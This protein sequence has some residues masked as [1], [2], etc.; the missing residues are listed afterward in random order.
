M[1]ASRLT[2]AAFA[3]T[4]WGGARRFLPILGTP[5]LS[6]LHT[7]AATSPS[8]ES[9]AER[10]ASL[11]AEAGLA[12]LKTVV[13]EE[14]ATILRLPAG[15]IDPAR[16]LSEMGMDSLMAVELRL[17]LESRLRVDLPLVSLAEGTSVASIAARL[18]GAIS[19]GPN[20]GELTAL[21]AR[22]EGAGDTPSP[23]GAGRAASAMLEAKSVAAE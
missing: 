6:E 18:A 8:D 15:G 17:A 3:D 16:P 20:A 7:N 4:N 12:L 11:D 23:P 1:I 21:V 10:L 5:L 22:H 9:L 2:V 14:A 13:A 19:T